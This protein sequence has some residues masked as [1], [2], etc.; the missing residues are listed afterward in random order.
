LWLRVCAVENLFGLIFSSCLANFCY[1]CYLGYFVIVWAIDVV[2]WA[3]VVWFKE[4]KD[5]IGLAWVGQW[6]NLG[7]TIFLNISVN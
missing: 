7:W 2:C 5:F 3:N 6:F 1:F 4:F